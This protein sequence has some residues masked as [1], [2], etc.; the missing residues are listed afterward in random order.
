VEVPVEVDKRLLLA[1]ALG[2]ALRMVH[3]HRAVK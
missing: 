1:R 2:P 3:T